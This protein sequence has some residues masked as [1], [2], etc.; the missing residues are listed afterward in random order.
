MRSRQY[1]P[2]VCGG[3]RAGFA[4]SLSVI[5]YHGEITSFMCAARIGR[6]ARRSHWEIRPG[7]RFGSPPLLAARRRDH[8]RFCPG[9]RGPDAGP[10]RTGR[11]GC[12]PSLVPEPSS[13]T[14]LTQVRSGYGPT[15]SGSLPVAPSL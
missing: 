4:I 13:D 7:C 14:D 12:C 3:M 11:P 1:H 9:T 8:A 15:V 6:R 10:A 2:Q 5:I